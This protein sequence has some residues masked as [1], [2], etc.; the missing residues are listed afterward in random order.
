MKTPQ[1]DRLT[2]AAITSAA[3]LAM[4]LGLFTAKINWTPDNPP[5]TPDREETD[6]LFEPELMDLGEETPQTKSQAAPAIKGKPNPASENKVKTPE[7]LPAKNKNPKPQ[8][9]DA[10]STLESKLKK[11]KEAAEQK[12]AKQATSS[13]ASK[14]SKTNGT[15]DG[16]TATSDGAGAQGIGVSGDAR[17]RTFISCPKPDVSLR[18]KTVVKVNIAIDAEGRVTE[19]TAS[20]SA[21]MTLRRKCEAAAMQARWSPKKG[22]ASTRGSITFTITPH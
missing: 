18:H 14:F 10:A 6:L 12:E 8:Q 19:A 20:G 22:A 13:L 11:E 2:A 15:T 16:K 21:D 4:F 17:G 3:V 7:R 1:K 9:P 5:P